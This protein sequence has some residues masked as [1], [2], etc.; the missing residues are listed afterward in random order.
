M[1]QFFQEACI[2]HIKLAKGSDKI[3]ITLHSLRQA[4]HQHSHLLCEQSEKC[5]VTNS[6]AY[7]THQVLRQKLCLRCRH[8]VPGEEYCPRN[9]R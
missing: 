2:N 5:D 9:T 1:T 6:N 4:K 8:E 7:T 3:S